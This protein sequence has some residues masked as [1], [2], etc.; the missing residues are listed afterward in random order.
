MIYELLPLRKLMVSPAPSN[1]GCE[2]HR[3]SWGHEEIE[4]ILNQRDM[5]SS[6]G[7]RLVSPIH[8]PQTPTKFLRFSA[9]NDY[10]LPGSG[11]GN[12]P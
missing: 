12:T 1:G 11:R 4:F 7:M 3:A 6:R 10:S 5:L 2:R 9:A 8:V